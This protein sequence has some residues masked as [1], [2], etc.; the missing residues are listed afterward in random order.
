MSAI[1]KNLICISAIATSLGLLT[2]LFKSTT[3]I[4]PVSDMQVLYL[5]AFVTLS[6]VAYYVLFELI[7]AFLPESCGLKRRDYSGYVE[8]AQRDEDAYTP[9]LTMWNVLTIVYGLG[10]VFFVFTYSF[11]GQQVVVT[12]LLS[13]SFTV[14]SAAYADNVSTPRFALDIL[15]VFLAFVSHC[16][17][18]YE[19][20]DSI[21]VTFYTHTVVGNVVGLGMPFTA[22]LMLCTISPHIRKAGLHRLV[23]FCEYGIP[24]AFIL[25]LRFLFI[26]SDN[27]SASPLIQ[28]QSFWLILVLAPPLLVPT[29]VLVVVSVFRDNPFAPLFALSLVFAARSVFCLGLT[30]YL[31]ILALLAAK[32]ALLAR[33]GSLYIP[34]PPSPSP[35]ESTPA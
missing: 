26:F 34:D 14:M 2:I 17:V 21:D 10:F 32:L 11:T 20:D 31:S 3:S 6:T 1:T 13:A 9:K 33:L 35:D 24:F 8:T 19:N 23:E 27:P 7:R 18:L 4:Q 29:I 5:S 30:S 28:D 25:A 15:S 22:P 12:F 16:L